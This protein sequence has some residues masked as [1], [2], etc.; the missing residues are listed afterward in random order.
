MVE[1]HTLSQT[2]QG[3]PDNSPVSV[4]T[5]INATILGATYQFL[6]QKQISNMLTFSLSHYKNNENFCGQLNKYVCKTVKL[7]SR[8]VR[9]TLGMRCKYE[10][11]FFFT[12]RKSP[13]QFLNLCGF[14]YSNCNI[15][16][17]SVVVLENLG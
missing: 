12:L 2:L 13:C 16:A 11:T 3:G 7:S 1:S 6:P 4:T 9:A 10:D 15:L 14:S 17:V 8:E 5:P